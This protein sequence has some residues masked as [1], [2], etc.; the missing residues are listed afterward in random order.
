MQVR[1]ISTEKR[2]NETI[3]ITEWYNADHDCNFYRVYISNGYNEI[4]VPF[5]ELHEAERFAKTREL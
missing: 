4:D 1:T 3:E 2:G 5:A